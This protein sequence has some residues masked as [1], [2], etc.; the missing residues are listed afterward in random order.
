MLVLV[1]RVVGAFPPRRLRAL[2]S[3]CSHLHVQV[4]QSRRRHQLQ[5]VCMVAWRVFAAARITRRADTAAGTSNCTQE[6]TNRPRIGPLHRT[7]TTFLQTLQHR[8]IFTKITHTDTYTSMYRS[9]AGIHPAYLLPGHA[10]C[11]ATVQR[12]N[13]THTNAH[14]L[15]YTHAHTQTQTL[16]H[17]PTHTRTCKDGGSS[18]KNIS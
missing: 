16:P 8:E 4:L 1:P 17:L 2:A 14:T 12:H 5:R 6:Q 7:H 9:G 3:Y 15:A 13:H 11:H 18:H 10:S